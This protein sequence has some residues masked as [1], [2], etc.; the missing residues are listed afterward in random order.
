MDMC[1]KAIQG[2][3][4]FVEKNFVNHHCFR[5]SRY[6]HSILFRG[7]LPKLI[8]NTYKNLKDYWWN[9]N[10]RWIF[11][12]LYDAFFLEK[13]ANAFKQLSHTSHAYLK[14]N[15]HFYL[16]NLIPT[17]ISTYGLFL[18]DIY[19]RKCKEIIGFPD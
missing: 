4:I 18:E 14:K 3:Q 9:L 10:R 13:A 5:E 19:I 6:T 12:W 2:M 8:V 16:C 15:I 17:H 1:V 7:C 11:K